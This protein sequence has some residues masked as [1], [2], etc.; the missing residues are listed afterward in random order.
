MSNIDEY[1]DVWVFT[2]IKDHVE[3]HTC[4]LEILSKGREHE[5]PNPIA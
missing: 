3:V 5:F 1:K 4:A 2:E